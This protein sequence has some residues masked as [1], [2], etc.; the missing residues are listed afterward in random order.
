MT[1]AA[2]PSAFAA[3]VGLLASTSGSSRLTANKS[4]AALKVLEFCASKPEVQKRKV[5]PFLSFPHHIVDG[6]PE[7]QKLNLD[8]TTKNHFIR[9]PP[10]PT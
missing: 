1:A 5:S 10:P 8:K 3:G 2:A 4:P 6:C 9:A 7:K